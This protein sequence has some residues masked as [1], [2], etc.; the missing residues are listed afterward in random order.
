ME[1]ESFGGSIRVRRP[2]AVTPPAGK[3]KD[4]DKD[5]RQN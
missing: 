3:A 2:G 4:K 5:D 1:M